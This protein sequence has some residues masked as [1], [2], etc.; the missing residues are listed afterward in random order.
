MPNGL[1]RLFSQDPGLVFSVM[2]REVRNETV[3]T[4][5]TKNNHR[6]RCRDRRAAG[7]TEAG[8]CVNG[9]D[10]H[11]PGGSSCA[12]AAQKILPEPV[13]SV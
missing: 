12:K 2:R 1:A 3:S 4:R 7:L 9:V 5:H 11:P 8:I 13:D 6:L 10:S